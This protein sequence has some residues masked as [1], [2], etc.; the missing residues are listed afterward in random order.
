MS[1]YLKRDFIYVIINFKLYK[2]LKVS[3]KY[4]YPGRYYYYRLNLRL[5]YNYNEFSY[6]L[7]TDFK[8]LKLTS[9]RL[10]DKLNPTSLLLRKT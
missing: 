6:I 5:Y 2:V 8:I 10:K 3:I 7:I 4:I 9:N 1:E